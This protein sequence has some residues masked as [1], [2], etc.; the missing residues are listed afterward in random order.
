MIDLAKALGMDPSEYAD[1]TL[2]YEV[3][4]LGESHKDLL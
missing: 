3:E 1:L 4:N 2:D